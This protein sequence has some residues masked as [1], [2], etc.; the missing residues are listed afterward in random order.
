MTLKMQHTLCPDCGSPIYFKAMPRRWK[1]ECMDGCGFLDSLPQSDIQDIL[2]D[3][4][5]QVW[6]AAKENAR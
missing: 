5:G 6:K 2:N 3:T 4:A 1:L